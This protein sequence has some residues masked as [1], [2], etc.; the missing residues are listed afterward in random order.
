MCL[1]C[2]LVRECA[3]VPATSNQQRSQKTGRQGRKEGR[4]SKE[5][6]MS[7][8][9]IR[10]VDSLVEEYLIHRGFTQTFRVFQK[11]KSD[12]RTHGK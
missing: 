9:N 12:D 1:V 6:K 7:C 4:K 3:C 2:C 10:G 8:D 5:G 11:E